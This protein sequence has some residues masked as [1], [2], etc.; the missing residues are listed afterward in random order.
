MSG[1]R[2]R[3]A[4]TVLGAALGLG[5]LLLLVPGVA[6][7]E[8]GGELD[9]GDPEAAGANRASAARVISLR[10]RAVLDNP[11]AGAPVALERGTRLYA[12]DHIS[13]EAES[14]V[15]LLLTDRSII[16]VGAS[17][18]LNIGEVA[19]TKGKRVISL[20]LTVGRIWSRVST[21]FSGETQFEVQTKTAVAGVRGTE[22]VV[23]VTEGGAT[24]VSVV[25]GSVE[26]RSSSGLL[27]ETIGPLLSGAFSGTGLIVIEPLDPAALAAMAADVRPEASL[28]DEEQSGLEEQG[29]TG[30]GLSQPPPPA[31]LD[32]LDSPAPPLDAE[33][34]SGRATI[35]G[36]LEVKE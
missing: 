34:G 35:K 26:M 14:S 29:R 20:R 8:E 36:T 11:G 33:P 9:G 18:T 1:W 15:R 10:G 27:H 32:I 21:F 22:F 25:S 31:K 19:V 7:G 2:S 28:S 30:P 4:P 3:R 24:T 5:A 13:T 23:E 17:T 6:R 16:D 12:S